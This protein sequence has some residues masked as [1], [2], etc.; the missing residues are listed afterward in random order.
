MASSTF[1][2]PAARESRL[3]HSSTKPGRTSSF[4]SADRSFGEQL[5]GQQLHLRRRHIRMNALHLQFAARSCSAFSFSSSALADGPG[6]EEHLHPALGFESLQ[7]LQTVVFVAD[8]LQFLAARMG[9]EMLDDA[10]SF[11]FS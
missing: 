10:L 11:A 8:L 4:F 1:E 2:N 6:R 9:R 3:F 7:H 5:R